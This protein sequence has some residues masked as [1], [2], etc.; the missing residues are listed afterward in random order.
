MILHRLRND[1]ALGYS[2]DAIQPNQY[3]AGVSQTLAID[4]LAKILIT[5]EQE[6]LAFV[7]SSKNVFVAA[8]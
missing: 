2:R 5:G 8:T 6:A 7:G 1:A 4:E 3:N